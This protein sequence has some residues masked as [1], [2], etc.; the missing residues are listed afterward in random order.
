MLRDQYGQLILNVATRGGHF[1][2]TTS[3]GVKSYLVLLISLANYAGL[4]AMLCLIEWIVLSNNTTQGTTTQGTTTQGSS[5][6]IKPELW[7]SVTLF[8]IQSILLSVV[9]I[10]SLSI[11][12]DSNIDPSDEE[13]E[14]RLEGTTTDN[15]DLI[16]GT[17]ASFMYLICGIGLSFMVIYIPDAPVMCVS[18][19]NVGFNVAWS[20]LSL[21]ITQAE[22]HN[23]WSRF[24]LSQSVKLVFVKIAFVCTVY[25]LMG[26]FR[27]YELENIAFSLTIT[28]AAEG[29]IVKLVIDLL[30]PR[31]LRRYSVRFDNFRSFVLTE[32]ILSLTYRHFLIII[33]A[34]TFPLAGLIG[35]AV[36]I[37]HLIVD[38]IRIKHFRTNGSY[39]RETIALPF[40]IPFSII[41]IASLLVYPM[42]FLWKWV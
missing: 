14:D 35:L 5:V 33:C 41:I 27:S 17:A 8:V 1:S 26:V 40:G 3:P 39:I 36:N 6:T 28:I 22:H 18:I 16:F 13:A 30:L 24:R 21:M 7:L 12:R 15:P 19:I 10:I 42:G 29:I 38:W 11:K 4:I 2:D 9:L 20:Q 32:E 25:A 23:K 37:I 31:I 34:L